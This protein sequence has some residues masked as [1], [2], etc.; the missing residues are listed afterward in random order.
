MGEDERLVDVGVAIP[1]P[2]KAGGRRA[3]LAVTGRGAFGK[4][5]APRRR[6]AARR[7]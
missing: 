2:A 6:R 5:P 3:V 1:R 7:R 4:L